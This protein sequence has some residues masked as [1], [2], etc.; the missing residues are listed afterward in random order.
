MKTKA[1][2]EAGWYVGQF[3]ELIRPGNKVGLSKTKAGVNRLMFRID[4]K[5]KATIPY[6]VVWDFADERFESALGAIGVSLNVL[7]KAYIKSGKSINKT[8]IWLEGTAKKKAAQ[9]TVGVMEDGGFGSSLRPWT[10]EEE[11][12]YAVVTGFDHDY[13]SKKATWKEKPDKS[14]VS[15][16]NGKPYKIPGG[17]FFNVRFKI[18]SGP[19]KGAVLKKD[20]WYAV[21]KD[22][23]DEWM[24]DAETRGAEFKRL[25]TIH[26]VNTDSIEPDRDFEDPENGLPELEKKLLKR[27][28]LVVITIHE[29]WVRGFKAAPKGTSIEGMPNEPINVATNNYTANE[30]LVAKLFSMVDRRVKKKTGKPAWR[31]AGQL[32]LS[33]KE[34]LKEN[35]LP[36]RF[37]SLSDDQVKKVIAIL[38]SDHPI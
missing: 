31:D 23:D 12:H 25:M 34:W 35:G 3:K 33:G 27:P 26:K 19:F 36:V 4:A 30:A 37:E 24:V 28:A 6:S 18:A 20:I 2:T 9:V 22:E 8:L 7:K 17:K 11:D 16:K 15:R 29:G 14:G 38:K 5:G 21:V 13:E 1:G 32:S 10:K